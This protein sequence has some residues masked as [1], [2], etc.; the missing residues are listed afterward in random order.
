MYL[1]IW[2]GKIIV[3]CC[4]PYIKRFFPKGRVVHV[5]E[6]SMPGALKS[7]AEIGWRFHT[8]AMVMLSGIREFH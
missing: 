6:I 4:L 1:F 2:K 3:W 7:K 5:K 8:K